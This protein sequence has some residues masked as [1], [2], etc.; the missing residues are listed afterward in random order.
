MPLRSGFGPA[1]PEFEPFLLAEIG[2]DHTGLPLTVQ[3]ALAR[4]DLDPQSEAVRIY[5][6]SREA[7]V[8]TLTDLIDALPEGSWTKLDARELATDLLTLMPHGRRRQAESMANGPPPRTAPRMT[9][10]RLLICVAFAALVA[11]AIW[12]MSG[13]TKDYMDLSSL[14]SGILALSTAD[15]LSAPVD[16]RAH[17]VER[18]STDALASA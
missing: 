5:E 2:D 18:T 13:S 8:R 17:A 10:P 12:G 15:H 9:I 1:H 14:P 16:R 3:S 11:Y 6:Q 4:L 7:A